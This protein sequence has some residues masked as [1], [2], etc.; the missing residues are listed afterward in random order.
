MCLLIY[1][2]ATIAVRKLPSINLLNL[3]KIVLLFVVTK[4]SYTIIQCFHLQDQTPVQQGSSAYRRLRERI[5]NKGFIEKGCQR[6][7]M[8]IALLLDKD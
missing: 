2:Q 6:E 1:P 4:A 3:E 7:D 8:C 5:F